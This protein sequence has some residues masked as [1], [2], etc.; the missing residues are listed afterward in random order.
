[1][2][3]KFALAL[4]SATLAGSSIGGLAP[5]LAQAAFPEMQPSVGMRGT[6]PLPLGST[7]PVGIPLGSTEIATPGVSPVNPSQGIGMSSCSGPASAGLPGALFDGGGLSAS[8]SPSCATTG[9]P[10]SPL[11][12]PSTVG[13]VG[14]PL[15]ANEL[16]GAGI[17]PSEPVPGPISSGNAGSI[18][19]S[20][21]P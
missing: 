4:L 21:N 18:N 8:A 16:G 12:S 10:A 6:S 15:G 7:R 20:G 9:A 13:R 11:S 5:A 14:I 1:V 2:R 17:S 3:F 19:G